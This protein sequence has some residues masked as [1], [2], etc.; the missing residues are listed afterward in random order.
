[1]G[2]GGRGDRSPSRVQGY[3]SGGGLGAS[4]KLDNA[5]TAADK[6]IEN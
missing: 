6:G 5:Q 4:Q 1:M 2:T 3:N